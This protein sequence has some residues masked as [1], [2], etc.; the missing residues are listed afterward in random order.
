MAKISEIS[1]DIAKGEQTLQA[2]QESR[3][4]SQQRVAGLEK[5]RRRHLVAARAGGDAAAKKRLLEI[6]AEIEVARKND[7]DDADA[8]SEAAKEVE[9]LKAALALTGKQGEREHLRFMLQA[10]ATAAIETR[11]EDLA[12]QLRSALDE[13]VASNRQLALDLSSFSPRLAAISQ[14]LAAATDPINLDVS[15]GVDDLVA[16]TQAK[17]RG[18]LD[19]L[20]CLPL[21]GE[22]DSGDS[23]LF[24]ARGNLRMNGLSF[25]PGDRLWSDPR[26]VV[27]LVAA[28]LLQECDVSSQ[29]CAEP[30]K[31][32]G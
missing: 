30:E 26:G 1:R 25:G 17:F 19:A 20:D 23:R 11:I 28:G 4:V 32:A 22:S 8:A 12:K 18:V 5:E 3:R 6:D 31:V 2:L 27:D 10:R 24:E 21:D 13:R 16:Q 29:A 7:R 9:R 15:R 14:D